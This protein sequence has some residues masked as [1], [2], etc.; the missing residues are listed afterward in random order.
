MGYPLPGFA[1]GTGAPSEFLFLRH[2]MLGSADDYFG[3][4]LPQEQYVAGRG[5]HCEVQFRLWRFGSIGSREPLD[6]KG[7]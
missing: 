1:R 5:I 2:H 4:L 3:G 7:L 6:R